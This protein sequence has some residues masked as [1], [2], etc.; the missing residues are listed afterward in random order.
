MCFFLVYL[1][2]VTWAIYDNGIRCIN[3]FL[4]WNDFQI[5]VYFD[6]DRD[7][8]LNRNSRVTSPST[9]SLK[10]ERDNLY[11]AC[12][13]YQ[14]LLNIERFTIFMLC[15]F[16]NVS[17]IAFAKYAQFPISC[18]KRPYVTQSTFFLLTV[19]LVPHWACWVAQHARNER[20]HV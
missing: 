15:P 13:C 8:F 2:N 4:F 17:T 12:H 11:R 9:K 6:L 18:W 16:W 3:G 7:D 20:C 10:K 14:F 5:K 1:R 19:L